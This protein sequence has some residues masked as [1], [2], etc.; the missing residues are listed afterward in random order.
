MKYWKKMAIAEYYSNHPI[1]ESIRNALEKTIDD[2]I[3]DEFQ[4]LPGRG[5]VSSILDQQILVGK[6]EFLEEYGIKNGRMLKTRNSNPF[7]H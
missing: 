4:E 7:V 6:R 5:I 1:A 3:I 2:S